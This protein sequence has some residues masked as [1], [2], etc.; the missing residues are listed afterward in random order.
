MPL[1]LLLPLEPAVEE[2]GERGGKLSEPG[3]HLAQHFCVPR[4]KDAHSHRAML[5]FASVGS[6]LELPN[7]SLQIIPFIPLRPSK[8]GFEEGVAW[9]GLVPTPRTHKVVY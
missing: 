1:E 2:P 8:N 7:R 4:N 5:S 9:V 3:R 6:S